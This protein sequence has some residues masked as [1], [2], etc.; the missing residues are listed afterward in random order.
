MSGISDLKSRLDNADKVIVFL[1]RSK[2]GGLSAVDGF[3]YTLP[4]SAELE[5]AVLSAAKNQA[6]SGPRE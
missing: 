3:L 6:Q 4:Y 5:S 2:D 1:R